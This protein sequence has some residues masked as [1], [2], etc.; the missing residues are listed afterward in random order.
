M[1]ARALALDIPHQ[2]AYGECK[3]IGTPEEAWYLDELR[4]LYRDYRDPD[5]LA[6]VVEDHGITEEEWERSL[7]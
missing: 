4:E 2:R 5:I 3:V 1:E 7:D 6:E